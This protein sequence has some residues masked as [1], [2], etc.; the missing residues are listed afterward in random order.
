MSQIVEAFSLS[1]AQ[2]LNGATTF[3]DA[4]AAAAAEDEDI[5]G[6]NDASLDP[7][8]GDYDNEGDDDILST[9]SWL[10]FADVAVQAGYLSLP[11]MAN[12]TNQEV[13]ESGEIAAVDEVQTITMTATG[14]TFTI[15]VGG[16]TTAPLAFNATNTDVRDAL[17]ALGSVD[18]GDVAVS[19]AVGTYVLT[20]GAD[21]AGRQ[22]PLAALDTTSLTGGTATITRTTPGKP[23]SNAVVG[24]DLWHEDSFNVA[25]KPMVV[26]MPSKDH[27]GNP[28]TLAIGL[29]KV[30]FR[31]I[32]FDGPSYKDGMKVN[33]A[34]RALK[35][36]VDE[37]GTPFSDG[38]KRVARILSIS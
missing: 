14:G 17:L 9:W 24:L 37:T 35:S 6:V 2:V 21:Y 22:V 20:Y 12:L 36:R 27:D 3:L 38:K 10:N 11:L 19:G 23:A 18:T 31:P 4:L 32:T 33:Y 7:D 26:R 5:Y 30:Q 15:S 28:R 1:H 25:P 34:G 13:D 8:I 16:E 29:Y